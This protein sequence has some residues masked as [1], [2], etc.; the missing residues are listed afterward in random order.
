MTKEELKQEAEEY[1]EDETEGTFQIC[2]DCYW[3]SDAVQTAYVDSAEPREKRIAE[4]EDKLANA[5]YQLEGR[6]LEIKELEKENAELKDNFKIA[7]DNEYEYSSLLTKAIAIILRLYNAGR[8]VLMCR[9]EEKAYDNL[10]NTIND[11][12]IEQFIIEAEK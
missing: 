9:A 8:D 6:D 10:S 11:K 12:S 2:E 1:Y 3:F 7:K 5:D 4:L